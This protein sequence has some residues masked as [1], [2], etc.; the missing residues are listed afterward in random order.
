MAVTKQQANAELTSASQTAGN[1][2]NNANA[3]Q[4]QGNN[5]NGGNNAS[6]DK[7]KELIAVNGKPL[8]F[9]FKNISDLAGKIKRIKI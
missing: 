5:T 4:N 2:N 6:N 3:G 7:Q 1:N 8:D 9:S